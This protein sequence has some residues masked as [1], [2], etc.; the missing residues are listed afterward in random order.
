M[1]CNFWLKGLKHVA[2]ITIRLLAD[3]IGLLADHTCITTDKTKLSTS[4]IILDRKIKHVVHET[5][6]LLADLIGLLADHTCITNRSVWRIIL[7]KYK[8]HLGHHTSRW[9]SGYWPKG[10]GGWSINIKSPFGALY[11]TCICPLW[12]IIITSIH[13][14]AR[15]LLLRWELRV[16]HLG[17]TRFKTIMYHTCE[18]MTTLLLYDT[19]WF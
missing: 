8:V 14:L 13:I 12:S 3:L 7:R 17:R 2:N 15:R 19:R 10:S 5:I 1:V 16:R 18:L 11:C 6:G 9:R 4:R